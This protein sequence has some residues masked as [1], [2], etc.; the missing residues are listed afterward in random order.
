MCEDCQKQID[1][2]TSYFNGRVSTLMDAIKLGTDASDYEHSEPFCV[3]GPNGPYK[4]RSPFQGDTQVK[5]DF[6]EAG[7]SNCQVVV[8]MSPKQNGADFTGSII[9]QG[10]NESMYD[11]LVLSLPANN[12][13]PVDS[14]W[15]NV[16]NSEN[17][18]YILVISAGNAAFV[19]LVF[20]QK[21]K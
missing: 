5:V 20:R 13:I 2:I 10:F 4:V 7:A 17:T 21:R 14:E 16:R 9:T 3:G 6:A 15:Y 11:G 19:N 18:V 1:H 8:S 12:T